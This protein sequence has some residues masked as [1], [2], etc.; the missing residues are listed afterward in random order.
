MSIRTI[1]LV[2][3]D[4]FFA[5]VEQVLDPSLAGKPVI[6]GGLPNERSVVATCS[7]EARA[8][9]VRV[10]M[11][12]AEAARL[13]PDAV[14]LKGDFENYLRASKAV[15]QVLE[16]YTPVIE[17][18]GLDEAFLDMTGC[19]R[20][21][22]PSIAA[23]QRMK[24]RIR[25]ATGLSVS[26]GIAANKLVAKAACRFAKPNGIARVLPGYERAFLAPMPVGDLP[27]VG[28]ATSEKLDA[29]N[30][31]TVAELAGLSDSILQRLFGRV[32][33]ARLHMAAAGV[34]PSPV[35]PPTGPK[36]I[37]RE[38]TFAHDTAE[39]AVIEGM[40]HYL[41]ERAAG[42][43]RREGMLAARLA[44]KIRYA[45]FDTHVAAAGLPAPTSHDRVLYECALALLRR[46]YTRRM[47]LRLVGV[48]LC[49]LV[50]AHFIPA[51]LFARDEDDR[52]D[53][54]YKSIDRVRE[55]FGFGALVTGRSIDLLGVIEHDERGFHLRTPALTR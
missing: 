38:T 35:R 12:L 49:A 4:A 10:A 53:R 37:G 11:P 15:G 2:D 9:G 44:V 41:T 3:I 30:I 29:F 48:T 14:F 25:C 31:R 16:Q 1:F 23:A 51:D 6:V 40:L 20:L 5:S 28:R 42:A 13:C 54:M 21:H 46:Q 18:V 17:P 36:S 47:G 33:G 34:D 7:Y 50:P 52:R 43:L 22:G 26:V 24:E 39:P 19:A 27:G 55:R 8:R 32:R 45:N